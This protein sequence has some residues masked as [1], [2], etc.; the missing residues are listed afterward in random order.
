VPYPL[1]QRTSQPSPPRPSYAQITQSNLGLFGSYQPPSQAG[2]P[3]LAVT[4]MLYGQIQQVGP[5]PWQIQPMLAGQLPPQQQQQQGQSRTHITHRR[6]RSY[7]EAAQLSSPVETLASDQALSPT[8]VYGD[9]VLHHSSQG[10]QQTYHPLQ[11]AQTSYQQSGPRIDMRRESKATSGSAYLSQNN[12]ATMN[13]QIGRQGYGDALVGWVQEART[14]GERTGLKVN[15]ALAV[16]SA[17]IPMSPQ[18]SAAGS[19]ATRRSRRS[20]AEILS[21]ISSDMCT[22]CGASF[23]SPEDLR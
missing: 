10:M 2:Y 8:P 22:Q 13:R 1:I 6:N 19:S 14:A 16:A 21:A 20:K 15:S 9:P 5:Q 18:E 4:P 17:Y 11:A 23:S 12:V 7:A 3:Q